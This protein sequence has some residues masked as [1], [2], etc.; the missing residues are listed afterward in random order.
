MSEIESPLGKKSFPS[1]TTK[2]VFTVTDDSQDD[3]NAP[4]PQSI[5]VQQNPH[6]QEVRLTP[7]QFNELQARRKEVQIAQR[8]PTS[9]ARQRVEILTGI[10]RMTK[11]LVIEEYKF[12]LQSLK[13]REMREIIKIVSQVE[14]P[15]EA[16]YEMRAQTLAR[17]LVK[18]DDRPV[19]LVL[20]AASLADIVQFI[21]DSEEHIVNQLYTAYTEMVKLHEEKFAVKDAKDAKEVAEE[22]KK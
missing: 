1:T 13:S 19:E 18:I 21:N 7:E 2:R 16:M 3:D 20:G 10:G 15:S 4:L 5:A 17:S 12:T 11:E 8:K 14:V 22:I 6:R 9:E